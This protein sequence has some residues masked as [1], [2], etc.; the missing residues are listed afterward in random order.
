MAYDNITAAVGC[1]TCLDVGQ[2]GADETEELHEREE[3]KLCTEWKERNVLSLRDKDE[4]EMH[5]KSYNATIRRVRVTTVAVE[6][7]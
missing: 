2:V 4:Q 1:T 6:N 5:F 7:R 3:L